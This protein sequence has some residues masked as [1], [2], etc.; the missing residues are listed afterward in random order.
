MSRGRQN[1]SQGREASPG[2]RVYACAVV[3]SPVRH[4]RCKQNLTVSLLGDTYGLRRCIQCQ[5]DLGWLISCFK[6]AGPWQLDI[7]SN[8]SLDIPVRVLFQQRF[9]LKPVNAE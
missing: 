2:E 4:I 6:A 7:W 5:V 3:R 1:S 8:T 9:T